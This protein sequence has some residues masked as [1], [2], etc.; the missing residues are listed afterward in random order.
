MNLAALKDA[1]RARLGDDA[2]LDADADLDGYRGDLSSAVGEAPA[3]AVRPRSTAE[4]IETM[5]LAAEA[6]IVTVPRGGG[7]GL[8]GGAAAC[9]GALVLSLERM[10][11]IRR[12]DRHGA[13]L[14]AEAGCTLAELH[15]VSRDAGLMLGLDHG[16]ASSQLGGNL[17]TNAGGKN[18][19]RY[20]M[21]REQV[22]G[23]EA[24]LSGGALIEALAPLPKNNTGYDLAQLL[25]GSEG[26]LGVITA[27]TLKLRP[28]PDR[29]ATAWLAVP[30]TASVL[31][32]LA[33]AR[34]ELGESL[35]AFELMSQAALGLEYAH[36]GSRG[37]EFASPWTVLL[38]AE[39][40]SRHFAIDDAM[41]AL[42]E[43][44]LA[45]GIVTDG[46]LAARQS[47]REAMWRRREG[48]AAGMIETPGALKG[49]TAV[50]VAEIPRFIERACLAV[51]A[52]APGC[53][54]AP[55]GHVG[56]GNI[57]FNVL[58]PRDGDA[59]AFASRHDAL[60]AAIEAVALGLGGTVSA[61]HGIG[62]IRRDGLL[63]MHAPAHLAAMR[64]IKLALDPAGLC[65]PGK[66]FSREIVASA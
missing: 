31:A 16:G 66:I 65:N 26:T 4:V 3:L 35:S 2:V 34:A 43:V 14:T 7:T 21:A 55:F 8:S 33:L 61:E 13:T 24:V 46:T 37:P 53:R 44:G 60:T 62:L 5:R 32:L 39:S 9:R 6:C 42:V 19:L 18:V 45:E 28:A 52:I 22:L 51:E 27:A 17:A 12:I 63:R 48:I 54:P 59:A 49:D 10:R 1:L 25:T 30:D 50:P 56:D 64:A 38:E 15:A 40:A 11:R 29:S 47:Q 20:G 57:H 23:I 36:A 58:P 41:V